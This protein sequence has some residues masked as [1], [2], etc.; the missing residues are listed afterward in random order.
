MLHPL[1]HAN[2]VRSISEIHR[3]IIRT[4]EEI[5][6]HT[7]GEINNHI[8][9]T[10]TNT[11]HHFTV[12]LHPSTGFTTIRF[13]YVDVGNCSPCFGS[14]NRGCCYFLRSHWNCRMFTYRVARTGYRTTDNNVTVHLATLVGLSIGN[15][16]DWIMDK[17]IS[18]SLLR[19][20]K[21]DGPK[22]VLYHHF[23]QT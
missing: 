21:K 2:T 16:F 9:I 8:N 22:P 20:Q 18:I 19:R 6:T 5:T 23:A 7:G 1:H 10:A 13:A 17:I 4:K 14:L 3:F 15:I 12:K 11:L